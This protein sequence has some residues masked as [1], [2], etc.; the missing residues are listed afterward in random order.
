MNDCDRG[1][2][3]WVLDSVL[4][5]SLSEHDFLYIAFQVCIV[6]KS[7]ELRFRCHEAG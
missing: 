5:V 1:G 4:E 7:E 2:V 6:K 3:K